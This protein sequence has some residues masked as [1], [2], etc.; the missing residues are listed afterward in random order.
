MHTRPNPAWEAFLAWRVG[1]LLHIRH[2]FND[3]GELDIEILMASFDTKIYDT[4][5][6]AWNS[7]VSGEG[8]KKIVLKV[9]CDT[10]CF[11]LSSC[12][13]RYWAHVQCCHLLD[14]WRIAVR[15]TPQGAESLGSNDFP[16]FYLS[17]KAHIELHF[18]FQGSSMF[19]SLLHQHPVNM[20]I[21]SEQSC[22]ASGIREKNTFVLSRISLC[23]I[24]P[25]EVIPMAITLTLDEVLASVWSRTACTKCLVIPTRKAP[26]KIQA[27]EI[28]IF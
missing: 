21:P 22:L 2:Q 26:V 5:K 14:I 13:T 15:Y 3:W 28:I 16:C 20:E 6:I 7:A 18:C 17:S 4:S 25:R 27:S 19:C 10:C 24:F 1:K 23:W 11:S 12:F 8:E 9:P